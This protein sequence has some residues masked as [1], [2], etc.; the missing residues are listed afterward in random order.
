MLKTIVVDDEHA[1]R[2]TLQLL[3]EKH[4]PEVTVVAAVDSA[5]KGKEAILRESP[6]LVFLDIQMPGGSGF[7]LLTSLEEIDFEVIFVSAHSQHALRAFNF[8]ALHYI[9]KPI[10]TKEL[11]VAI[12]RAKQSKQKDLELRNLQYQTLKENFKDNQSQQTKIALPTLEGFSFVML[13][14]IV[15]IKGDDAYSEVFFSNGE[16]MV[17]SRKI[18]QMERLL[19]PYRFYRIHKSHMINLNHLVRYLRGRGGEV[20]MSDGTFIDVAR[21][22]KAEFIDL[23]LK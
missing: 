15:R 3:L 8:A 9:R 7:D 16:M 10:N 21:R 23:I 13:S 14:E 19:T 12:E 20:E 22:R 6:D 11:R 2:E 4:H 1:G 17:V 5:A 18:A